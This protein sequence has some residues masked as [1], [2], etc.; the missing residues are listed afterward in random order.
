MSGAA[1]LLGASPGAFLGLTLVLFGG[2]A[3]AT[4]RALARHWRPPWQI[5]PYAALLAAGDRFLLYALFDGWLL[6]ASGY[7]IA[8]LMLLALIVL[9]YRLTL[10]RGMVRQYPWLYE[11]AGPL[12]WRRRG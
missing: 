12:S 1:A 4:G 3:L 8:A 6:S 2:A 7:V 9:A 10:V 5:L 11:T